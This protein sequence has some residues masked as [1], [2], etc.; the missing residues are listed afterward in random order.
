LSYYNFGKKY[1][2]R[3]RSCS[4]QQ[5]PDLKQKF[6]TYDLFAQADMNEVYGEDN[7]QKALNYDAFNFENSVLFNKKGKMQLKALPRTAQVAS[8]N[9]FATL[10]DKIILAGNLLNTEVETPR[11]D[12]NMGL[13]LEI[14]KSGDFKTIS[15]QASG[16]YLPNEVKHLAPITVAGKSMILVVRNGGWMELIGK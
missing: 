10:D 16:L 14:D 15:S 2:V 11:Q 5:I 12:G 3:G 8:V 6:P 9:A 7:L 1:P 4:S 13:V